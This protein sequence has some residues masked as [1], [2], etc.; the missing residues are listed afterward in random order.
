MIVNFEPGHL[1]QIRQ[2]MDVVPSEYAYTVM[3]NSKPVCCFGK[4]LDS[5]NWIVWFVFAPEAKG[6]IVRLYRIVR[7]FLSAHDG[8]LWIA[9]NTDFG[10][11]GAELLGFRHKGERDGFDI[12][13]R[14][15]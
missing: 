5:G 7:R 13:A 10:R 8:I 3:V 6:H 9:A 2:S 4:A 1:E 15:C 12:Y 14:V 11:R